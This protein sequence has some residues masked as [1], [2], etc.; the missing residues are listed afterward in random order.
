M[1]MIIDT[2]LGK[3]KRTAW[4]GG[5][6]PTKTFEQTWVG[7]QLIAFF[8]EEQIADCGGINN[9][10]NWIF[11]DQTLDEKLSIFRN[12][13]LGDAWATFHNPVV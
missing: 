6:T 3:F 10:K 11:G 1:Q 12:R 2:D 8:Y 5:D 13:A 9:V 4:T 7:K